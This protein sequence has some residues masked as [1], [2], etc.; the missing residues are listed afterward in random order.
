MP[1][2]VRGFK[3]PDFFEILKT[4]ANKLF[5]TQTAIHYSRNF[6][7]NISPILAFIKVT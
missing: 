2:G 6:S 4:A 1:Y 7:L 5:S 3:T